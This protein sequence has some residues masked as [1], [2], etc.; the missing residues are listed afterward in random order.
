ML[1]KSC[2]GVVALLSLISVG[3]RTPYGGGCSN[4]SCGGSSGA[5]YA[6]APQTYAPA[7]QNYAPAPQGYA[8]APQQAL[9]PTFNGGG[10]G[11]R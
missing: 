4:G 2:L 3:C 8:P 10:S 7:P 9:P 11:S 5:G 1:R 6:P